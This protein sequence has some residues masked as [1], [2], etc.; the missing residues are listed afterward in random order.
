MQTKAKG[1]SY[2]DYINDRAIIESLRIPQPPPAGQSE[3]TWPTWHKPG[4]PAKPGS[5]EWSPGE[6][7]PRGVPWSH[8]EVLFIRTHQAFEVWF[9]VFLHE[10]DEVLRQAGDITAVEGRAITQIKLDDRVQGGRQFSPHRFPR[11][12]AAAESFSNEFIKNRVHLM[13]PPGRHANLSGGFGF[14]AK[15]LRRWIASLNRAAAALLV[16]IPFFDV[17]ATMSPREF[18]EF[19]G[20]L[21]P[22][23]GF[24]STQF[25]EIEITLGLRELSKA[26]IQPTGGTDKEEMGIVK[27]PYP[28]LRPTTDT[29]PSEAAGSFYRHH[30]PSDWS[31]LARRFQQPS[32]RDLVYSVLNGNIFDWSGPAEVD[33]T[34]DAFAATNV[35][36]ALGP[37]DRS[38]YVDETRLA[39][40]IDGLG[41]FLSHRETNVAAML[42]M[43]NPLNEER[44][45]IRSFLDACMNVDGALLRWRD[46][47]IR[48]VESMI[49]RRPGTG[50]AGVNY[51]RSTTD[52]GLA[53][54]FTHAFPCLW[55]AKSIVQA[56]S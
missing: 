26:R 47:H 16:T 56:N 42:E 12:A 2:S 36:D 51:L 18:L 13:P 27:P 43:T 7:W 29:P 3:E 5:V 35:T 33:K 49:G 24:G 10:I 15:D 1:L 46:Q 25:R 20:R 19:R 4:E 6:A 39:D 30:L 11:L 28:M 8:H 53:T 32:L 38:K 45:A 55:Q 31:R 48:F 9:A 14:Q 34:L 44:S 22:A 21:S 52:A 40:Q 37:Y 23:S 54:F 41:E 50:G 17:L